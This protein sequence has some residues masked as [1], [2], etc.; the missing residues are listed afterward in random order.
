[1]YLALKL[2]SLPTIISFPGRVDQPLEVDR[3]STGRLKG[4]LCAR[5]GTLDAPTLRKAAMGDVALVLHS[6]VVLAGEENALIYEQ[7]ESD[8]PARSGPPSCKK[9]PNAQSDA[10]H[11]AT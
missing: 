11:A 9:M 6:Q 3:E 1:M 10:N 8:A 2:D 7:L 4:Q 5:Y